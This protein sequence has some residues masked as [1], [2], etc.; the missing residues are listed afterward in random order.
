MHRY[1]NLPPKTKKIK[2]DRQQGEK[3][4]RLAMWTIAAA[5]AS[6]TTTTTTITITTTTTT[7]TDDKQYLK[8]AN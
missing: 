2:E 8:P 5:A 6:T 3:P 4:N 1:W 7:T